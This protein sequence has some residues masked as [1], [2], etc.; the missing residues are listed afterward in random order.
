MTLQVH[1]HLL[2]LL[3]EKALILDSTLIL[4]DTHFGKSASFRARGIPVPEGDT[5]Q[6]TGRIL[7][8]LDRHRPERLVIAG[9]FLHA[10]EGKSP[11]VLESLAHFFSRLECETHLVLGNHDHRAGPLPR[12]WPV[13][14]H[15]SLALG[16]LTIVHDPAEAPG[17]EFSIC[18]HL[19]PVARIKDGVNTGFR[20]PCFW[21]REMSLILPSFGTFTGGA[22]AHPADG[23]RIFAPLHD[24]VVE[25][26]RELMPI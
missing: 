3:P 10:P 2:T 8:L 5:A 18:G 19:H 14:V 25:I 7:V 11:A 12:D 24:R 13:T 17:D 20:T 4:A 16:A 22:I 1:D 9:D 23:E 26:P 21:L 15:E 6:D